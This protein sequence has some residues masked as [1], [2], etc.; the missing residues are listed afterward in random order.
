M[1]KLSHLV[2]RSFEA[3]NRSVYH[4]H[5]ELEFAV[6]AEVAFDALAEL[7]QLYEASYARQRLPFTVF[8]VRH[9][10][11]GHDRTLI[12]PG[13][14]GPTIWIDVV[15]NE[16]RGFEA[17]YREAVAVMR[18]YDSQPHL[19]KWADEF[20]PDDLARAHGER[21]ARF[22]ELRERFDPQRR[23]DNRSPRGCSGREALRR[24]PVGDEAVAGPLLAARHQLLRRPVGPLDREG[25][26]LQH[27]VGGEAEADEVLLVR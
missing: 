27:A 11:E 25:D 2:L 12:G 23:F 8:E 3:F 26:D 5:E 17:F 7:V 10:P 18:R 1:Q 6:A 13:R 4:Q 15:C 19:G 22:L 14:G 20:R 21:F 16:T 9:T 24:G